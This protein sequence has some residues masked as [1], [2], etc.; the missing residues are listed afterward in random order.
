MSDCISAGWT[1]LPDGRLQIDK[2]A[3]A[4]LRYGFDVAGILATGDSITSIAI[5]AQAGI[6]A[7]QAGYS[8]TVVSCRVAGGTVGD[9]GS[10]TLR[11]GTQQ[12][13]TDERTMVFAVVAR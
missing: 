4:D 10:V 12:G 6:S 1:M 7:S 13:D 9:T 8:G 3:G 5:A 2:A 11:W